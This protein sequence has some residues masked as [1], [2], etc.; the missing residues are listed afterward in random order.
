MTNTA[1]KYRAIREKRRNDP[2]IR[3]KIGGI[4]DSCDEALKEA[5]DLVRAAADMLS[6]YPLMED[7]QYQCSLQDIQKLSAELQKIVKCRE[8]ID[9]D[10]VIGRL[11][12]G[13]L[14]AEIDYLG[15]DFNL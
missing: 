1:L 7:A 10:R 5:S 2:E 13:R 8:G 6:K 12:A 11:A 15:D 3:A 14:G 9:K 4:L